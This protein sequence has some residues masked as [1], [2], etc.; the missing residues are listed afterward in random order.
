[1]VIRH[2]YIHTD[3]LSHMSGTIRKKKGEEGKK[4]CHSFLAFNTQFGDH[5]TLGSDDLSRDLYSL[6]VFHKS[7]APIT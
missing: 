2:L 1:M 3:A 5:V 7:L 6:L 4:N